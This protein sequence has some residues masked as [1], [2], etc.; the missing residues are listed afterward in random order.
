MICPWPGSTSFTR[1]RAMMCRPSS[2]TSH[3]LLSVSRSG[4]EIQGVV[5]V[6]PTTIRMITASSPNSC[7]ARTRFHHGRARIGGRARLDSSC[8]SWRL[9]R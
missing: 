1:V 4:R 6:N 7:D 8:G 5:S 3:S 9:T 2:V